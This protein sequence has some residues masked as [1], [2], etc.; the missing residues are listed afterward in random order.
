M[1]KIRS[2]FKDT[3]EWALHG[4]GFVPSTAGIT[5]L[6]EALSHI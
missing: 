4:P 2:S 1:I 3:A 6:P 5:H